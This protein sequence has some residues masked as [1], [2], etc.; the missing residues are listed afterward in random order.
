MVN[1]SSLDDFT[2]EFYHQMLAEKNL[3]D[4]IIKSTKTAIIHQMVS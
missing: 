4:G 1:L 2:D 3:V